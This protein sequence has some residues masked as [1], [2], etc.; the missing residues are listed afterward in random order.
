MWRQIAFSTAKARLSAHPCSRR[1]RRARWPPSIAKQAQRGLAG[2]RPFG[3]N[4][5]SCSRQ[6]TA[7]TSA[8]CFSASLC[9]SS[10]D[11]AQV[12]RLCRHSQTGTDCCNRS[13][14]RATVGVSGSSMRSGSRR[15]QRRLMSSVMAL[16]SCHC[17]RNWATT[18]CMANRHCSASVRRPPLARPQV[19][20][21]SIESPKRPGV[22]IGVVMDTSPIGSGSSARPGQRQ[23][24][25]RS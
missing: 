18:V 20:D 11:H 13:S 4:A 17:S 1:N 21:P 8:S 24:A 23:T 7:S 2:G 10:V 14:A 15:L 6:E 9:A 25:A 5:I 3:S 22:S 19:A 12:R 16:R